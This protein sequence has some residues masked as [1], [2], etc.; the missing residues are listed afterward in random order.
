MMKKIDKSTHVSKSSRS[1]KTFVKIKN[2][3][4]I[5]NRQIK[6][7]STENLNSLICNVN[8]YMLKRIETKENE[9]SIAWWLITMKRYRV[10]ISI[11]NAY[12]QNEFSTYKESI[13]KELRIY[14]Y[15]TISNIIDEALEKKQLKYIK[16]KN[17]DEKIKRFIPSSHLVSSYLNWN[18][19]N[20]KNYNSAIEKLNQ[21]N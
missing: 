6:L 5:E 16:T 14:S 19:R 3:I 18:I 1:S 13:I 11:M 20:I 4:Q 2:N 7:D 10:L 9:D 8:K 12:C 15:K 17:S 21:K